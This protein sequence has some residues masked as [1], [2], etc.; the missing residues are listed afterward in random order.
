MD[1]NQDDELQTIFRQEME[2]RTPRLI[3]GARAMLDGTL[4][5]ELIEGSA[6]EAHT[7]KGTAKVMGFAAIGDAAGRLEADW[8]AVL[9]RS[10]EPSDVLG[11]GLLAVSEQLLPA[12][13]ADPGQGTPE[14]SAALRSLINYS[15]PSDEN[16]APNPSGPAPTVTQGGAVVALNPV[17]ADTPVVEGPSLIVIDGA[18]DDTAPKPNPNVG[19]LGGLLATTDTFSAGETTGV[20]TSKLYR[21]INRVAELRLDAEALGNTVEALRLAA[22]SSPAEVAALATRWE[23]AVADVSTAVT[24]IQ[25]QSVTLV[26]VPLTTVTSTVPGLVR[27]LAKKTGRDVRL[28]IVDDDIEVDLQILENLGDAFRNLIVNSIEHGIENPEERTA[29]GK[30]ATGTLRVAAAIEDGRLNLSVSDDGRGLDWEALKEAAVGRSLLRED[31]E[32]TQEQLRSFLFETGISTSPSHSELSGSGQGFNTV[33]RLVREMRGSVRLETKPGEGTTVTIT[34]PAFQSLQRALIVEAAGRRWGVAELAVL[35]RFSIIDADRVTV[36]GSQEVVWGDGMLPIG[37]FA[38]AAGLPDT[39][40]HRDVVVL[41]TQSGPAA[42]AVSGIMG[43]REVATK[44]LGPLVSGTDLITGAALLGGGE[45]ALMLDAEALGAANQQTR[46]GLVPDVRRRV[47][48]V[49]D[50]PG[51]RQIVAGALT[52]G[53]FETVVAGSAEEAL[54]V[55]A[56]GNVDAI[57]VDYSMPGSD[58]IALVEGVRARSAALPIVMMSAV[59]ERADQE[60]ARAAGVNAYFDKSDFREGALV[61]TLH[62]LLESADKGREAQ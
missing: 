40:V 21:L 49:D 19:N 22:T 29:A 32:V 31:E 54:E 12:V 48:V 61:S 8:K 11:R 23:A 27:F 60:R 45:V 55:V 2:E 10:V 34:V 28:E 53:G 47:L 62:S 9:D 37:S 51:V 17:E 42:L 39:D 18:K 3:D 20:D 13:E 56:V 44:S 5:S 14:L 1:W 50:S 24:E 35:D 4:T 58:G 26:A 33:A 59:A 46:N 25:K 16:E 43:V 15:N 30:S 38:K 57:V 52:A 6:R 36:A 7:V 41:A